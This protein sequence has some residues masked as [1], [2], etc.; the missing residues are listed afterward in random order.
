MFAP[1]RRTY[2][3]DTK[4]RAG[5]MPLA[6]APTGSIADADTHAPVVI[7][8]VFVVAVVSIPVEGSSC[9]QDAVVVYVIYVVAA[10]VVVSPIMCRRRF[11]VI[12]INNS[13]SSSSAVVVTDIWNN[14]VLHL[15]FYT[16]LFRFFCVLPKM[17]CLLCSFVLVCSLFKDVAQTSLLP[18][19]D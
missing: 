1:Y 19:G 13:S 5:R 11:D 14:K 3:R 2:D 17:C 9:L 10:A 12:K 15:S 4:C 16:C 18:F 6:A 7:V 8:V